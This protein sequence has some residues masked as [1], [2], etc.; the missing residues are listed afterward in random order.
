MWTQIKLAL[1]FQIL[2]S[3]E[4]RMYG[5]AA[6]L[7][8]ALRHTISLERASTSRNPHGI[9]SESSSSSGDGDEAAGTDQDTDIEMDGDDDNKQ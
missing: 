7:T 2:K 5:Q 1:M 3:R 9:S 4:A 8:D 6:R